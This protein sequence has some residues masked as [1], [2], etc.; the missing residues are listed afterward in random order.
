RGCLGPS[1]AQRG[2]AHPAAVGALPP[3]DRGLARR[4]LRSG[5][6][7]PTKL[8]GHDRVAFPQ[9]VAGPAP[10]A[11]L[12]TLADLGDVVLEATQRLDREVV[13]HD[14]PRTQDPRLRAT[15]DLAAAHDRPGDVAELR[16]AE[17]LA[18][19]GGARSEE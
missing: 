10:D 12:V 4:T 6:G 5:P 15:A 17:D 9:V 2:D 11:A 8:V 7:L 3:P 1:P 16:G 19:L 14:G 13:P 18:D